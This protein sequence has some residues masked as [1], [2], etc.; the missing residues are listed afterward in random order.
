MQPL[1]VVALG[2]IALGAVPWI[3]SL[4]VSAELPGGFKFQFREVKAKQERQEQE[5]SWIR[6]ILDLLISDAQRRHLEY[7]A[8]DGPFVAKIEKE[9]NFEWELRHLV[10]LGFVDRHPGK[11]FRTLFGEEGQRNVKDHLFI[12]DRGK[13]YLEVQKAAHV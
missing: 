6:T 9:S 13:L 4:F 5:L 10:T 8:A 1:D 3:A 12:T 7:L 2:L 11:G